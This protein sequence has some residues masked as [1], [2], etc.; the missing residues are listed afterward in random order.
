MNNGERFIEH[1]ATDA[2]E[3]EEFNVGHRPEKPSDLRAL[4]G[5]ASRKPAIQSSNRLETELYKGPIPSD[6]IELV[7]IMPAE[8]A[9][10]FHPRDEAF[11]AVFRSL[12]LYGFILYL[13]A[14]T[15][16][17]LLFGV[18][19]AEADTSSAAGNLFSQLIVPAM[20]FAACSL[21]HVYRISARR[22]WRAL[23]P[24]APFLL[25]VMLSALW[26]E[27]PELTIRRASNELLQATALA[28]LAACFS[29]ATAMLAALFR[30]FLIIGC[31]DLLSYAFFPES[32]TD[33]GFAGIHGGKNIA[34][35]FFVVA[36]P[37]Y[38]LGTLDKEISGNRLLGLF[39]LISGIAMLVATQSKTSVG[40]AVFG[41]S[42]LLLARALS[43]NHTLRVS[44]LLCFLL[45]LLCAIAVTISL[46]PSELLETL[47]GDPTLTGRDQ[48]WRFAISKF[49]GDPVLGVGYGAIWQVGLEIQLALRS[50]GLYFVFNEA[51]DGY[52]EIA[53]QLGIVGVA[54]LLI[55][56]VRTLL[57]SLSY[58]A[59]IEKNS[60]L[61][62]G[63]LTTY[64]FWALVLSNITES[65]YFQ[66]GVGSS[67]VLIF[68]GA[69]VASPHR[70]LVIVSTANLDPRAPRGRVR[71]DHRANVNGIAP[72]T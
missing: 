49:D 40:A 53:A 3:Q 22:L 52:L 25:V 66:A 5:R 16:P 19:T 50:M 4:L 12:L 45:G 55:F 41:F 65:L 2:F 61:G 64:I 56:L 72:Q 46:G 18:G 37:V 33:L 6:P 21:V 58:W 13:F 39:S 59:T 70:R 20:F 34:G 63:A 26:S 28:L 67:G 51:H 27:Y 36:L 11:T 38:L 69:F 48:I 10:V 23:A 35:E 7:N 32:I 14:F 68:L 29:N 44:L 42:L 57:N 17:D 9:N 71:L 15:A 47:I 54:C 43:R 31:L 62:A 8:N 60:L 1:F 24:M 30:A